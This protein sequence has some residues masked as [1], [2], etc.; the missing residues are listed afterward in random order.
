MLVEEREKIKR[1]NETEVM[2]RFRKPSLCVASLPLNSLSINLVSE[3]LPTITQL[4]R[5]FFYPVSMDFFF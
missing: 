1:V 5:I 2:Y 4:N 3:N